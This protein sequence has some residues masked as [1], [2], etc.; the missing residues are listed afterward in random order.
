MVAAVGI[1]ARAP[2]LVVLAGAE[3]GGLAIAARVQCAALLHGN[4]A[5]VGIGTEASNHEGRLVLDVVVVRHFTRVLRGRAP[6]AS[7]RVEGRQLEAGLV[8]AVDGFL[9]IG[10]TDL[11]ASVCA[12]VPCVGS[13]ALCARGNIIHE[14][15]CS[16]TLFKLLPVGLG[17]EGGGGT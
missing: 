10:L 17:R 13:Y 4:G 1:E 7:A 6:V 2:E 3:P 12:L 8:L 15:S 14:K 5:V 9:V 11:R 16:S